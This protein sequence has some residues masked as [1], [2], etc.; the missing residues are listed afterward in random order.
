MGEFCHLSTDFDNVS[1]LFFLF[2]IVTDDLNCHRP[3]ELTSTSRT[4][5]LSFDFIFLMSLFQ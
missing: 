5:D 4:S 1:L 3:L 2:I